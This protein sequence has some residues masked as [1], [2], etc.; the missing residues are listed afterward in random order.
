QNNRV[1]E[2]FSPLTA[3]P[4][5]ARVFGQSN[6]FITTGCDQNGINADGLCLQGRPLFIGHATGT[7][8]G[9]KL[10]AAGSG[11]AVDGSNNLFVADP[12]NNRVVIYR[13]ATPTATPTPK[14]T[15][16]PTRTRTPTPTR[17]RTATPTR[18]P[19]PTRTRTATPTRTPTATR[20]P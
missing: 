18:T 11:L 6:S 8:T 12:G 4:K 20:T 7:A 10:G 9:M 19:T 5:A 16:T 1:L 17:T 14:P 3:E 13:A 15:A 2:Y